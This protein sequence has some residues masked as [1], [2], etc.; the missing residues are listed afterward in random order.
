MEWEIKLFGFFASVLFLGLFLPLAY[1]LGRDIKA[2]QLK[3][4]RRK[5]RC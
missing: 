3:R 5:L 2:W 4:K 1:K